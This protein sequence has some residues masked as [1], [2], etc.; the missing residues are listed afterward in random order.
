MVAY[1]KVDVPDSGDYFE[2]VREALL[3]RGVAEADILAISAATGQGVT[4]L[5]RRLHAVLDALPAQ[6]RPLPCSALTC[7]LFMVP[8][9]RRQ[10][11]HVLVVPSN[12]TYIAISALCIG[13]LLHA[14][15]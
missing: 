11:T 7:P 3:G 13:T 2:E 4:P 15:L 14:K 10:K 1:N 5:V 8:A 6:A 12:C 9:I